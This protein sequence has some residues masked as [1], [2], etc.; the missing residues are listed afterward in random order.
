MNNPISI[1]HF[2]AILF[3]CAVALA[4]CARAEVRL[5]SPFTSHMVLQRD[6]KVPVWGTADAGETVTV[7]FAGQ[8]VSAQADADGHWR[9]DLKPLKASAESRTFTVTGSH[10]AK[11]IALDDV[12]VGEVW[13]ASGQS[14]MDF[15]MSKKV[16]YFAG[17]TNEEAEIAAANYPLIRMFIGNASQGLQ[18]ANDRHRRMA[19]LHS[20][21]GA[22]ILRHR[23]LFRARSAA[24]NQS[25]HRHHRRGI[26]R[27][28]GGGVD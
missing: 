26:W 17:V 28:H 20:R 9:V 14:N 5:A 27:E 13:L 7:E 23:L 6:M 11:P 10:T 24:G 1:R 21:D 2:A 8:K 15:T 19:G 12:V 16:K 25:A 4:P 3:F 22:G 18:A